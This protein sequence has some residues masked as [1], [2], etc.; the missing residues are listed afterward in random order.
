MTH[1][2]FDV[3]ENKGNWETE[4]AS[5]DIGKGLYLNHNDFCNKIESGED[6]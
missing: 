1:G 5:G 4:Y 3:F 6:D 2:V